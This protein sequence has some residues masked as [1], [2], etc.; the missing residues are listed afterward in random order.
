MSVSR[1]SEAPPPQAPPVIRHRI[2]TSQVTS[3]LL[4]TIVV[5]LLLLWLLQPAK[6]PP[7]EQLRDTAAAAGYLLSLAA[8]SG[9]AAMVTVQFWKVLFRPRRGFHLQHLYQAFGRSTPVILGLTGARPPSVPQRSSKRVPLEMDDI[10]DS[11]T[12]I[13]MGHVR[14]A[15]DYIML[16]P[17]GFGRT[18]YRIAGVQGKAAVREYLKALEKESSWPGDQG[19]YEDDLGVR[20]TRIN[21]ALVP[22]R[23]FVEQRLNLLHVTLRDRWSRRVRALAAVVAGGTGLLA[24]GLGELGPLAKISAIAAAAV[25]GGSFAWLA[26]DV[27][28]LVERRRG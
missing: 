27:V 12:E 26:R 17:Q 23:F 25:W 16:R 21:D 8:C 19:E 14:S 5:A 10:L 28:S 20:A 9:V 6:T 13:L 3:L 4:L 18:L 24:I 22:V 1:S 11:P 2:G 7:P 15:A